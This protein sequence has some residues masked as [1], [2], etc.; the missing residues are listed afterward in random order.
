MHSRM[1]GCIP[2]SEG[3]SIFYFGDWNPSKRGD[4]NRFGNPTEDEYV[5]VEMTFFDDFDLDQGQL[6]TLRRFFVIS[7]RLE[8][9]G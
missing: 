2:E 5:D 1:T 4:K 8:E 9:G 6:G 3:F 7:V